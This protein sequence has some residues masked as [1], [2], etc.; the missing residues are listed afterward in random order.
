M[1]TAIS[2]QNV[3]LRVKWPNDIYYGSSIKLGGVIV[4]STMLHDVCIASIGE[5]AVVVH[6]D[7]HSWNITSSAYSIE[8]FDIFV[9]HLPTFSL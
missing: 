3:N 4:K 5:S 7:S 8:M 2:F 6:L 9:S 1:D